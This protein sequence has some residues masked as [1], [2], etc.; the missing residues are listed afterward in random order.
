MIDDRDDQ[1]PLERARWIGLRRTPLYTYMTWVSVAALA[2]AAAFYLILRILPGADKG[3]G[4]VFFDVAA[5]VATCGFLVD[6]LLAWFLARRWGVAQLLKARTLVAEEAADRNDH[7]A[8]LTAL[9]PVRRFWGTE[10]IF[11]TARSRIA[12]KMRWRSGSAA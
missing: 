2:L 8:V 4:Q 11:L 7:H 6:V 10:E 9:N 12:L 1:V 5:V 3:G